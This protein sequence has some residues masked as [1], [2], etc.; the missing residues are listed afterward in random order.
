L[1]L[2]QDC[3]GLLQITG[4]ND[5]F[6]S[7]NLFRQPS[8]LLRLFCSEFFLGKLPEPFNIAAQIGILRVDS[9]ERVQCVSA[10]S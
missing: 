1:R 7:L 9:L 2:S 5:A 3:L 4:R 10:S 6:D 8:S